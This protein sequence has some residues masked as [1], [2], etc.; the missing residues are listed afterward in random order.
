MSSITRKWHLLDADDVFAYKVP[1]TVKIR[2]RKLGIAR[3]L[4]LI[5]LFVYVIIYEIILQKGYLSKENPAGFYARVSVRNDRSGT[6]TTPTS[7]LPFCCP[8]DGCQGVGFQSVR[9]RLPCVVWNGHDSV[10]PSSEEFSSFITTRVTVTDYVPIPLACAVNAQVP[11]QGC[12]GWVE[13]AAGTNG[14]KRAYYVAGAEDHTV[15][16]RHSIYGQYA[17]K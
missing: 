7:S 13:Q 11:G 8:T 15:L 10:Y 17:K 4:L 16:I 5:G 9:G 12:G 3:I 14:S 1:R 2:D 6:P